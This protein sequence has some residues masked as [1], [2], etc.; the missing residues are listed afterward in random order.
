MKDE[1]RPNGIPYRDIKWRKHPIST[2]ETT[3]NWELISGWVT[4]SA[5]Y[6][7]TS[8]KVTVVVKRESKRSKKGFVEE[9]KEEPIIDYIKSLITGKYEKNLQCQ[10][11]DEH[12]LNMVKTLSPYDFELFVANIYSQL[13]YLHYSEIG[14]SLQKDTDLVLLKPETFN[15]ITVQIKTQTTEEEYE[16]YCSRLNVSESAEFVYHTSK[17]KLISKEKIKVLQI[18]NLMEKITEEDKQLLLL[19]WLKEKCKFGVIQLKLVA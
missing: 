11:M 18:E 17:E 3:F 8:C 13:S 15:R 4:K 5:A 2:T 12:C 7:Q 6:Q 10:W 16:K 19:K 1:K 14:G 9:K